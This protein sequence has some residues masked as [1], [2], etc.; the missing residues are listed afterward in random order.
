MFTQNS[1]YKSA[2]MNIAYVWIIKHWKCV[3]LLGQTSLI[4]WNKV[5]MQHKHCFKT[6][7]YINSLHLSIYQ[8]VSLTRVLGGGGGRGRWSSRRPVLVYDEGW[9]TTVSVY[10][11]SPQSIA[12]VRRVGMTIGSHPSPTAPETDIKTFPSPPSPPQLPKEPAI[13]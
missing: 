13:I 5:F 2:L 3:D 4:I 9:T 12:V 10:K 8:S 11:P 1:N 7:I 6:I